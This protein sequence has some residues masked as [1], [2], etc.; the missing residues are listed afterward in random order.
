LQPI[1]SQPHLS[2][3][4]RRPRSGIISVAKLASDYGKFANAASTR[5]VAMG[6]ALLYPSYAP[7]L[8]GKRHGMLSA[9]SGVLTEMPD[10]PRCD[11][12]RR[13]SAA[14]PKTSPA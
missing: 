10:G 11:D 12:S 7:R 9:A 3:P 13:M 4:I 6:F 5:S 2:S 14:A 1:Y 8:P